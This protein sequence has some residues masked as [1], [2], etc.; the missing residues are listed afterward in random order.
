[1]A[2]TLSLTSYLA[3]KSL[4]SITPDSIFIIQLPLIK[5]DNEQ[6]GFVFEVYDMTVA[7]CNAN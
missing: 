2:P 3:T 5:K 4:R 7:V 6:R 1:M